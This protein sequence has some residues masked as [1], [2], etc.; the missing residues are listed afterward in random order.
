MR[1]EALFVALL[2]QALQAGVKTRLDPSWTHQQLDIKSEPHCLCECFCD[3]TGERPWSVAIGGP[4]GLAV[5][6]LCRCCAA[7]SDVEPLSPRRR[8]HG[9]VVRPSYAGFNIGGLL[10]R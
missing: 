1:W 4:V 2:S 10:Q 8:G 6:L 9:I 3:L 5:F 7:W